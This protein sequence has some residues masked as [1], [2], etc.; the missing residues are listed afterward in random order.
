[1][2][3]FKIVLPIFLF[4]MTVLPAALSAQGKNAGRDKNDVNWFPVT[5]K[6]VA[7]VPVLLSYDN[8]GGEVYAKFYFDMRALPADLIQYGTLLSKLAGNMNTE[9]YSLTD[10]KKA[11]HDNSDENG[12]NITSFLKD[13]EDINLIPK[14][15]ISVNLKYEKIDTV[16]SLL[17]K[18]L[19]KT[20]YSDKERIEEILAGEKARLENEIKNNAAKYTTIRLSSYFSREGTFKDLTQGI[21]YYKF[22]TGLLKNF[23]SKY[24]VILQNILNAARLVFNKN[25]MIVSASLEKSSLPVYLKNVEI[26][27]NTFPYSYYGRN[28]NYFSW[29]FT[30]GKKNEGFSISAQNGFIAAGYNFKKL[31]YLSGGSA[32][33]LN[34][35]LSSKFRQNNSGLIINLSQSGEAVFVKILDSGEADFSAVPDFVGK[36]EASPSEMKKYIEAA[37]DDM[38]K[39]LTPVEKRDEAVKYFF[40]DITL[41]DLIKLHKEILSVTAKDIRMLKPLVEE[42]LSQ[43]AV[44]AVGSAEKIN[45]RREEFKTIKALNP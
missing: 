2:R 12:I 30:P 19:T 22:V 7:Y 27:A 45:S 42:V 23:D 34:K 41:G 36:F 13:N 11:L 5:E 37:L 4:I 26:L 39:K 32:A 9:K 29:D 10:L 20:N 43:K 16:F 35:I 40:E 31:G 24:D 33:V 25:N 28:V 38:N 14:L 3:A 21:G 8:T 18:I 17:G 15:V 6:R 44:C 1:M